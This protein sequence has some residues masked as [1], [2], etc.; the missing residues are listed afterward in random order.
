MFIKMT[1]IEAVESSTST[2]GELYDLNRK[3]EWVDR[4]PEIKRDWKLFYCK[5]HRGDTTES[6]GKRLSAMP[7][8]SYLSD[9]A[10]APS[11]K[12]WRSINWFNITNSALKPWMDLMVPIKIEDRQ[13]GDVAFKESCE[14][15]INNMKVSKFQYF[16]NDKVIMFIFLHFLNHSQ[17]QL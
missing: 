14:K 5:V 13:V 3:V 11:K 10:Y 16:H 8:F 15:A 12:T 6:I 7:Q 17:F 2:E 1:N 9:S 4:N